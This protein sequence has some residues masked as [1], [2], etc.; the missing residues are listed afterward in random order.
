[1]IDIRASF[2]YS[3]IINSNSTSSSIL[4]K[5]PQLLRLF[6][7]FRFLRFLKLLRIFKVSKILVKY[8]NLLYNDSVNMMMSLLKLLVI[9]VFFA[10]M[11]A[12]LFFV[13]G[14]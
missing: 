7:M 1:M 6:K 4:S 9:I 10:H 11:L 12:C 14:N 2:P 13:V 3:Y 5:T 8:E